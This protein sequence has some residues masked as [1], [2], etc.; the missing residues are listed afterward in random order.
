[1]LLIHPPVSKPSEAPG[2]L[3]RLC[4]ALKRN[5]ITF[6]L[7]DA[8]IEGLFAL[9]NTSSRCQ[10]TWTRRACKHLDK[11]VSILRSFS[12]YEN[13]DRYTSAV[14]DLS[15]VLQAV[16]TPYGAT[17]GIA[18]YQC[19]D[20][21]PVRS[22]DLI[23]A[24]EDP[25]TNPFHPYFSKRLTNLLEQ[26]QPSMVGFSLNYLSQALTTF[27]M[28]GFLKD[29]CPGLKIFIG[30]GLVTSWSKGPGI[31]ERFKGLVDTAISG[32]GEDALLSLSSIDNKGSFHVPYYDCFP[33]DD[34]LSPVRILPFSASSGCYWSRCSFCPE[35]SERTPYT[36][37]R[38]N[39]FI[40]DIKD[41][42]EI[43]RPGLIHF[44]DNALSPYILK[45]LA[46]N[47]LTVPWYGFARVTDDLADPE[48][49]IA[50]R[51]SGCVMLKL[52][53]ESGDQEV[54]D[55]LGKGINLE[56]ASKALKNLKKAGIATYVYLL[57]GT[58]TEDESGARKTLE[59]TRD[60]A[61]K[62]GFLNLAVFNLPVHSPDAANM[63]TG[64]FYEGDLCLYRAFVH[65]R[66]WNRNLV[67]QFLDKEFKR[68]SSVQEILKNDPPVFTSN[69]A[70][71]F[72]LPG[73]NP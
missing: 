67:R 18:N 8:N 27:A 14:K 16:S 45:T 36:P 31:G 54:L 2:G 44:L 29:I 26:G 32:P 11:N 71:F 38:V 46:K 53:I 5:G 50:L 30:G 19:G 73:R 1:M 64:S 72:S 28:I 56:V 52:G 63:D 39:S 13:I 43:Q 7:L 6:R 59:F 69:H 10:D 41:M 40:N 55:K 21:S 62:I 35:R 15:R 3:A 4:G 58:P 49:C 57:F 42:C 22:R 65:P 25:R 33:M 24:A 51:R 68:S 23:K 17:A 61:D 60:H 9:L 37:I 48:Y 20:M 12:G 47:P 70:S 66:G 34:Y